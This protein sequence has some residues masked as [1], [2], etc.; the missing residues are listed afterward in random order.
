MSATSLNDKLNNIINRSP[1]YTLIGLKYRLYPLISE[2]QQNINMNL[3][4]KFTVAYN[5]I[6]EQIIYG[7]TEQEDELVKNETMDVIKMIYKSISV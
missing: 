3:Y 5:N 4:I 6:S 2:L 1:N 7:D